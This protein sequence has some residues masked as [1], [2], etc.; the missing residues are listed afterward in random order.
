MDS[1]STRYPPAPPTS[2]VDTPALP[3]QQRYPFFANRDEEI[4]Y[5]ESKRLV[6]NSPLARPLAMHSSPPSSGG[7]D[8]V[9]DR[10]VRGPG[11]RSEVLPGQNNPGRLDPK[12]LAMFGGG[13]R[14][15]WV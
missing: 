3:P 14:K 4:S 10:G 7:Y 13:K 2:R 12:L 11:G 5:L 6:S 9:L 8:G 15:R 1:G